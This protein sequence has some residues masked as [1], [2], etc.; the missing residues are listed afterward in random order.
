MKATKEADLISAVLR[1]AV[2]CLADGD[3]EGEHYAFVPDIRVKC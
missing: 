1:Y 2:R 3:P